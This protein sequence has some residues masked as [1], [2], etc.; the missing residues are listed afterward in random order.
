MFCWLQSPSVTLLVTLWSYLSTLLF[1]L[2]LVQLIVDIWE[3]GDLAKYFIRFKANEESKIQAFSLPEPTNRMIKGDD[4]LLSKGMVM[5]KTP[6]LPYR[7]V[8]FFFYCFYRER[9][10]ATASSGPLRRQS[11]TEGVRPSAEVRVMSHL[12][13]DRC[14]AESL[15]AGDE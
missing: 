12:H 14:K 13:P 2:L 15:P 3:H 9:G 5:L 8:T 7:L 11:T 6:F 4:S 10:A 1:C